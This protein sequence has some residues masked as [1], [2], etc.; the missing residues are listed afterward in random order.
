MKKRKD[1]LQKEQDARQ[2]WQEKGVERPYVSPRIHENGC[3]SLLSEEQH[4]ELEKMMN[5]QSEPKGEE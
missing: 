3:P 1:Y 2:K 5:S 4:Q